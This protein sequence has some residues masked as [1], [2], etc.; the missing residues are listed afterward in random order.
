MNSRVCCP[1]A[2]APPACFVVHL[3]I[4]SLCFQ[5]SRAMS[6]ERLRKVGGHRLP[7]YSH[8]GPCFLVRGRLPLLRA[9]LHGI[10]NRIPR[11]DVLVYT[12]PLSSSTT[13]NRAIK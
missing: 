3:L 1:A 11:L 13:S 10:S 6:L 7:H 8:N 2:A 12:A 9:L 5:A 4:S